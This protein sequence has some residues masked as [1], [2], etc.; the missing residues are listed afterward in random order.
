[1]VRAGLFL[2]VLC[3]C[4]PGQP[5]AADGAPAGGQADGD[6]DARP[7][8]AD[9]NQSGCPDGLPLDLGDVEP[10]LI[11]QSETDE[12]YFVFAS[13]SDE[14]DPVQQ[15][16]MRLYKD[17]GP[18]AGGVQPGSYTISGDE[19]DYQWCDACVFFYAEK[20]E[21]PYAF[22]MAEGGVV[23]LE[24]VG[25]QLTGTVEHVLLRMIDIRN[26]GGECDGPG[27]DKCGNT[28]CS[29]GRCGRQVELGTCQI[30]IGS[31]SF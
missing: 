15:F 22:F 18:F 4:G 1:M 20:E 17:R 30:R 9:A 25:A 10:L 3:A 19:A 8:D 21:L 7:G 6:P 12:Y 29:Q 2:L 27:D 13:V 14:P 11:D 31:L 28:T 26:D 5:A 24:S 16:A 23:H